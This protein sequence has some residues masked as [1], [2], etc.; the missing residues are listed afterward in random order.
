MAIS[1]TEQEQSQTTTWAS[2]LVSNGH[3]RESKMFL[4][5]FASKMLVVSLEW[6]KM[7]LSSSS[8]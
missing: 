5:A 4:S 8:A 6:R 3:V 1:S 7:W 2:L